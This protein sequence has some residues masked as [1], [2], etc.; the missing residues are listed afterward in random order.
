MSSRILIA[1][2]ILATNKISSLEG[3]DELIEKYEKLLKIG[4]LFK[5]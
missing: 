4:K 3:S 5:S 1:N 2:K